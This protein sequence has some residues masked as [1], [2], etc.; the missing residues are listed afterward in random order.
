MRL[1]HDPPKHPKRD[2]C[3]HLGGCDEL[4]GYLGLIEQQRR[5]QLDQLK[6]HRS[7]QALVELSS[8]PQRAEPLADLHD[9][10]ALNQQPSV[11]QGGFEIEPVLKLDRERLGGQL[12]LR[13][14]SSSPD[15]SAKYASFN[16]IAAR[17][18]RCS[19]ASNEA[20]A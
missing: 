8:S 4:L 16:A 13:C 1:S 9:L 7:E 6:R 10:T 15:W 2:R 12:P 14:R 11:Q 18:S 19:A 17:F 3:G 20:R 5:H